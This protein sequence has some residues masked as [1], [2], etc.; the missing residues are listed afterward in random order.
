MNKKVLLILLLFI[1]FIVNADCN[2]VK[3]E[4]YVGLAPNITYNNN[5][6]K[7]SSKF[8]IVIYNIFNGMYATYN[9]QKYEPNEK[10]EVT[11][12]DVKQ[13]ADVMISIF[14]DDGCDEI[15]MITLIE[16]YFNEYYGS[17]VCEGYEGKVS[18]CSSQ[19]TNGP[20]TKDVIDLAIE[21]YGKS[22]QSIPKS[23]EAPK[24]ETILDR[25]KEFIQN[26]GIKIVLVAVT[27]FVT[28]TI[29]SSK[30]R[31]IKHGI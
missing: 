14:A 7:S 28:S 12:P 3:H 17:S 20:V 21:S 13:G 8:N 2:S 25:I 26:W 15:K 30:F 5:Y 22:H 23:K 11:I 27:I 29:F 9:K 16:P 6:S 18:L 1:P 4:E 31:K 19:F 24:K 10:N